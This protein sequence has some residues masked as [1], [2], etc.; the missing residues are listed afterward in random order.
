MKE[1]L[2]KIMGIVV[3]ACFI[4][5]LVLK[6]FHIKPLKEGLENPTDD[7]TASLAGVAGSASSYASGIKAKTVQL[8]DTMLIQKY[9]ADY[10]NVIINMEDYLSILMLEQVL[11]FNPSDSFKTIMDRINAINS[12]SN[13]KKSLNE[14]MS[15]VDKQ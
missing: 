1:D 3:A 11:S 14:I 8:Q 7:L 15:F 10:E 4:V 12:L 6:M 9:R 2:L 5:Y 13:G